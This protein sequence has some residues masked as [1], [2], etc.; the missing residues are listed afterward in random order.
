MYPDYPGDR[1]YDFVVPAAA[2]RR[3]VC[4]YAINVGNGGPNHPMLGCTTVTLT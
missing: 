3:T 1:G 2:G 4:A